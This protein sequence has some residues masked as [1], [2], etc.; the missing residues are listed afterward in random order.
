MPK[1]D[2]TVTVSVII[3]ICSIVSP[4]LTA[5][6]NNCHDT[7]PKKLEYKHLEREEQRQHERDIFETYVRAAGACIN[8]PSERNFQEFGAQSAAAM[9]AVPDDE[10]RHDMEELADSLWHE[11]R[12][13]NQ[14]RLT[15][16]V[17]SLNHRGKLWKRNA[18]KK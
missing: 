17:R 7:K 4:I 5:I 18:Y 14:V 10:I 6:I 13:S 11:S 8:L 16:I 15:R 1:V 9:Y 2:L 12:E 3:A